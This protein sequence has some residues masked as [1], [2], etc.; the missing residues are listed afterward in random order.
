MSAESRVLSKPGVAAASA[1]LPTVSIILPVLNEEAQLRRCL[2]AVN[3]QTYP[4]I[5]EILVA[6]GGSSDETRSVAAGFAKV[7]VVDNP[8]H[9]RPAGLNAAIAAASGEVIVRVDA[10]TALSPDYVERCVEA[11]ERSGA[12]IVGGQMR[13][14]AHDA[15]QRGIVAAMTSRLGAGPAAFRREGGEARFVDT[16]YLGAFRAKTIREM[17]GYDEWSGGNEDAE[18]AWRAQQ[19]GGV[20]LDPAIKSF[21]LGRAGL[22][23]L[24]RQYYRY[25]RNR[26]RTI[27]KHPGS[28]SYRQL[29]VPALFVG[30]ASP[31]RRQVLAAY[32]A[33]VLGRGAV[34]LTRDPAAVPTLLAALPTMHAAWGLGF[35]R[36]MVGEMGRQDLPRPVAS[37]EESRSSAPGMPH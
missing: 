35:L 13:Y 8:R 21:Y 6:D 25:G 23:P 20:Y 24:A 15:P 29:A 2:A 36:S 32:V 5:T 3:E 33:T 28:L 14:E 12:A 4:A 37:F 1:P 22:G 18:L 30:L 9:I 16:V 31:W 34:E 19:F 26:A 11:L 27:R 7:R 10:R 17:E